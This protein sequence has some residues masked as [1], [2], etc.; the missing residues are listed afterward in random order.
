MAKEQGVD[1]DL[2]FLDA[3]HLFEPSVTH[4]G[5]RREIFLR[6]YM[7]EFI[8]SF[9][10]HLKRPLIEKVLATTRRDEREA[11]LSGFTLPRR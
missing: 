8:E 2:E 10:E 4:I 1:D 11:L 9:A 5:L 3:S 6:S 7:Y